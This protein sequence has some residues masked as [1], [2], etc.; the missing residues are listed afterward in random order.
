MKSP[1]HAALASFVEARAALEETFGVAGA[2]SIVQE[3]LSGHQPR[4]GRCRNGLEYFVHGI[5][6]TVVLADGCPA[7]IDGSDHG[8]VFTAYDVRSFLSECIEEPPPVE[9][10]NAELGELETAGALR[11][12]D[13]MTYCMPDRY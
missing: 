2:P 5:G 9:I 6:Y 1:V 7:H 13:E 10:V 12:V 3:V 4:E 11:R 8:D